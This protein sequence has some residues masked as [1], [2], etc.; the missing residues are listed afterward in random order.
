MVPGNGFG[1]PTFVMGII[2]IF[3]AA[4]GVRTPLAQPAEQQRRW[5][6][7]LL[8]L[9]LVAVFG[10]QIVYGLRLIAHPHARDSLEIV[11]DV[12]IASLLIGIGRA[13]E[14]VG[15]LNAGMFASIRYL[16]GRGGPPS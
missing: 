4:A 5:H 14:L 3:F 11:G 9:G 13:W 6:Q 12:L 1:F 7:L 2:G 10:V 15:T 8:I 16:F